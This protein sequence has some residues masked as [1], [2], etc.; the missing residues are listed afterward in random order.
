V[1]TWCGLLQRHWKPSLLVL[2]SVYSQK[3]LMALQKPQATS[4]SK[5]AITAREGSSKLGGLLGLPPLSVVD[6]LHASS[7]G[8][9]ILSFPYFEVPLPLYGPPL[10]G[11]LPKCWSLPLYFSLSWVP[12]FMKFAAFHQQLYHLPQLKLFEIK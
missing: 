8:F 6:T 3:V 9:S 1:L 5:H 12:S 7:G 4:N 10:M 11:C 2:H